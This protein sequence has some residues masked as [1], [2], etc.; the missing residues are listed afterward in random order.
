M[1]S[2]GTLPNAPHIRLNLPVVASKTMM[3]RLPYPSATKS[4]FVFA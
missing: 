3:R 4:S 1:P 2:V